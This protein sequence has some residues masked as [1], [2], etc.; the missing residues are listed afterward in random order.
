MHTHVT[1]LSHIPSHTHTITFH[2]ITYTPS[3]HHAYLVIVTYPLMTL[4]RTTPPF[5]PC[6]RCIPPTTASSTACSTRHGRSSTTD[7]MDARWQGPLPLVLIVQPSVLAFAPFIVTNNN[8]LLSS[9]LLTL[10]THPSSL[11]TG[12]NLYFRVDQV[13]R[14][15]WRGTALRAA[16]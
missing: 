4:P 10:I 15:R 16:R 1:H 9:S 14:K 5:P 12:G 2:S 8:H 6:T 7:T 13:F 3:H 11:I